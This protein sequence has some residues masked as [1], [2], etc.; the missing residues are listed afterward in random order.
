MFLFSFLAGLILSFQLLFLGSYFRSPSR[1]KRKEKVK[2]GSADFR[3]LQSVSSAEPI[4]PWIN[5]YFRLQGVCNA[6]AKALQTLCKRLANALQRAA[7]PDDP[8]FSGTSRRCGRDVKC[9]K[10]AVKSGKSILECFLHDF[11]PVDN[12][13]MP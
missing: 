1:E 8:Y 3:R 11:V 5:A 4:S 9:G 10:S 13:L 6:F 7:H 2:G 12:D